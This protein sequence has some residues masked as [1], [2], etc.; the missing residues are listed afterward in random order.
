MKKNIEGSVTIPLK[1]YLRLLEFE[2]KMLDKMVKSVIYHSYN[3]IS[4]TIYYKKDKTIAS[5]LEKNKNQEKVIKMREDFIKTLQNKMKNYQSEVFDLKD[6]I[7]NL[8]EFTI[9]QFRKWRKQ[10]NEK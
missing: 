9:F 7:R 8:S 3:G 1:E 4:E 5:V 2:K 10:Q 6:S